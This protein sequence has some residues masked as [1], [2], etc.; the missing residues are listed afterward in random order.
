LRYSIIRK[1]KT[2]NYES[3]GD[4]LAFSLT[5]LNSYNFEKKQKELLYTILKYAKENVPY[6]KKLMNNIVLDKKLV[7]NNLKEIPLLSKAIIREQGNHIYS[8]QFEKVFC[9]WQK[10][11]GSTGEPLEFPVSLNFEDVHGT[12]LYNLMGANRKDTIVAIDGTRIEDNLLEKN[13]F[14]KDGGD[15]FPYGSI[16]YSTVYM[17][18][19]N[20]KYYLDHLNLV[21]PQIMRGYPSGFENLAKYLISKNINLKFDLKGIYLTSESFDSSVTDLLRKAFSCPIFGQYGHSEV[22]VFAFTLADSMEYICSPLYGFTEVLN[23]EGS[24]VKEGETGEIVVTG[25]SNKVMPFIRYKTGDM[26][27]YGGTQNGVVK[28]KSLQGRSSDYIISKDNMKIYLVGLIFGGHLESFAKIKSWQIEQ[29][30]PGF[31]TVRIVKDFGFSDLSEH[32]IVQLFESVNVITNI[33]YV[34]E[35]PLTQRGK[36]KFL[37]QNVK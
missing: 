12:C 35:I 24:H 33:E 11:G 7:I 27:V 15:N 30:N 3:T 13:I 19:D 36:R 1:I 22:S 6:Y 37:I 20:I 26:A 17:K 5:H 4:K 16:H 9:Y 29:F 31:I 32:E 8:Q 23:E 25:Y 2:Y 10:T 21:K 34:D 18:D 28:L 14:W